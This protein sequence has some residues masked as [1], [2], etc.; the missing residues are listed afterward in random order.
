MWILRKESCY[1]EHIIIDNDV[2]PDQKIT[3]C[4][5]NFS[6]PKTE[7]DVNFF[8]GLDDFYKRFILNFSQ[9]AK[10]LT[11][12]L[13]KMH[14]SLTDLCQNTFL[15]LKE[16]LDKLMANWILWTQLDVWPPNH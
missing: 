12:V 8:L 13:K 6:T 16:L 14:I 11:T 9:I 2:K 3:E 4:V 15:E 5:V 10:L 1:Y 7:K